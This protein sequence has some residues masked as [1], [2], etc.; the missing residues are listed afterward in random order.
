MKALSRQGLVLVIAAVLAVGGAL[1]LLASLLDT[2]PPPAV[3]VPLTIAA[4][5]GY[6]GS[7]LVFI[8]DAKG[9][10]RDEGL[11]VV[12]QPHRSGKAA[13]ASAL[14]G[15]AQLATVAAAPI[16]FSLLAGERVVLVA[17]IATDMADHEIVARRDRGITTGEDLKG[18]V[19]GTTVGTSAHYSLEV[20]LAVHGIHPDD[21]T[22]VNIE[23]AKL[24]GAIGRGEI[25][26]IS[27]WQPHVSMAASNLGGNALRF[28]GAE[29]SRHS[30]YMAAPDAF[31]RMNPDV[32]QRSLRAI[33]RAEQYARQHRAEAQA[34]V[35]DAAGLDPALVAQIWPHFVFGLR[36]EQ[37]A[38]AELEDQARWARR[39]GSAG[40]FAMPDFL[41]AMRL[42]PLLAVKPRAVTV[43]Y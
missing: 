30:F 9:Y 24:A 19:V 3:P 14:A 4:T 35:S 32:L 12:L 23:P 42:E 34:I 11:T 38:L 15:K 10:F 41:N 13:L 29:L 2:K 17:A 37:G 16:V 27:S 40:T 5:T 39:N 1:T 43:V 8:A 26:A 21:V 6:M 22:L 28:N 25:D 36:L 7:A 31:A 20:F 33:D 18:K